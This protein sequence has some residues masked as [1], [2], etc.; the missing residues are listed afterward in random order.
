MAMSLEQTL[1]ITDWDE[2]GPCSLCGSPARDPDD[3]EGWAE[4]L[5]Q[6]HGYRVIKDIPRPADDGKLRTIRLEL[7]GWDI[8]AKFRANQ[9][10][11]VKAD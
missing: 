7:V 4:H 2:T 5:T 9:R 8:N 3:M 1:T 6:W 11:T 10:V